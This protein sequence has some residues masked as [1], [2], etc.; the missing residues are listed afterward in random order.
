MTKSERAG[1]GAGTGRKGGE[2]AKADWFKVVIY[3]MQSTKDSTTDDDME[4]GRLTIGEDRADQSRAERFAPRDTE[5]SGC[6]RSECANKHTVPVLLEP[7][8]GK[9]GDCRLHLE[10]KGK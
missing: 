8:S 2:I 10:Q 4:E 7:V 5:R 9:A 3:D 6:D 1:A